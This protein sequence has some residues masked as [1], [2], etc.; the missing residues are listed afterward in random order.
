MV[1][2]AMQPK[3]YNYLNVGHPDNPKPYPI[4]GAKR[5]QPPTP[6]Q[7]STVC[8]RKAGVG[9]DHLGVGRCYM[10]G[11]RNLT[12]LAHPS[13]RHGRYLSGL[14]GALGA[15]Y[16]QV[17]QARSD[18]PLDLYEELNTQRTLL[19]VQLY[20]LEG[21]DLR[22][23]SAADVEALGAAMNGG[24]DEIDV[25]VM[26]GDG[27]VVVVDGGKVSSSLARAPAQTKTASR[28][29]MYELRLDA[30]RERI[31]EEIA[32]VS[33]IGLDK[34]NGLIL[35]VANTVMNL[36]M[37]AQ[38]VVGGASK[39]PSKDTQAAGG[40]GLQKLGGGVVAVE[41]GQIQIIRDLINDIV[42]TSQKISSMINQDR[43][44]SAE[45]IFVMGALKEVVN[46][47]LPDV[48]QQ[49]A[50]I[51]RLRERIPSLIQQSGSSE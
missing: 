5:R 6:E 36:C 43:L 16:N 30:L 35:N 48:N 9:T 34:D 14:P 24:E 47:F 2:G 21:V 25:G 32:S 8:T 33:A 39:T 7:P 10:H 29:N 1:S 45:I 4:C 13:Y 23:M 11:G 50:F 27:G 51:N 3:T 46:E 42:S 44:T 41:E 28:D 18:N 17:S 20:K 37:K 26:V 15:I 31:A 19:M 22:K 38:G 40:S 49:R 12:G